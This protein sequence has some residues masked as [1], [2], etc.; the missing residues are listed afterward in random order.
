MRVVKYLWASAMVLSVARSSVGEQP[1]LLSGVASETLPSGM[2][3]PGVAKTEAQPDAR[4]DEM[5][6]KMQA[7]VEEVAQLYGSP[8]FLQVFTNDT[9]RATELRERLKADQRIHVI[10][11][12]IEK[13]EGQ[14][15]ALLNEIASRQKQATALGEKLVRQRIALDSLAAAVEQARRAV[16]DTTK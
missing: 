15:T 2:G 13:L 9:E 11:M 10:R 14:R 16:E 12:E 6:S 8:L 4:Y 7:A 1:A 3:E 5:L